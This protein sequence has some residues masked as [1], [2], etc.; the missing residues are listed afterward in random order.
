MQRADAAAGLAQEAWHGITN[1]VAQQVVQEVFRHLPGGAIDRFTWAN[2]NP[3]GYQQQIRHGLTHSGLA[4]RIAAGTGELPLIFDF[5]PRELKPLDWRSRIET[6]GALAVHVMRNLEWYLAP[7][8]PV[9]LFRPGEWLRRYGASL[10]FLTV[11]M[12]LLLAGILMDG[13][14][15]ALLGQ[16]LIKDSAAFTTA[17]G[18]ILVALIAFCLEFLQQGNSYDIRCAEF[19]RHLVDAYA[20]QEDA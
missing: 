3:D 20:D 14:A 7:P 10:F 2:F 4:Q 12:L 18:F 6:P 15:A 16:I 19:F 5:M 9:R 13:P 1:P 17:L 8:A 11:G